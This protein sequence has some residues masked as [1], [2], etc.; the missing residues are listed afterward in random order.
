MLLPSQIKPLGTSYGEG[1]MDSPTGETT[2][3]NP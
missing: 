2:E 1:T 3:S